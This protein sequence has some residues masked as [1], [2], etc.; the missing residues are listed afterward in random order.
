L[1]FTIYSNTM[2]YETKKNEK[3]NKKWYIW[4]KWE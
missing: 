3:N 4:E 2:I 1:F